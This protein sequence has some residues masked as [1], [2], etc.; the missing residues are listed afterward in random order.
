VQEYRLTPSFTSD[1]H[2]L[3][4][5]AGVASWTQI[6]DAR[7]G[8]TVIKSLPSGNVEDVS[9]AQSA[10]L[11]RV[12]LFEEGGD[13]IDMVQIGKAYLTA[14]HPILTVDG[15]LLASQAAAKG[16]GQLPSERKFSQLCG[17]QLATGGN[18]LINTSTTQ[19]LASV[20]IEAATLGYRFLSSPEPLN[21][22]FPT[23]AVQKTG[24]RYGSA[25]QTKPSYSQVTTLHHKRVSKRPI[26]LFTPET[27]AS[28][29]SIAGSDK[30]AKGH[31]G[32]PTTGISALGAQ[33]AQR[34]P[35]ECIGDLDAARTESHG[36]R[37]TG[38]Q[39]SCRVVIQGDGPGG[40]DESH[41]AVRRAQDIRDGSTEN[42]TAARE[43]TGPTLPRLPASS[44]AGLNKEQIT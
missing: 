9:G 26:P 25:D 6:R 35:E 33:T 27:H 2:I 7:C 43:S 22:N 17:L 23:Y 3:I 10:T 38:N 29:K 16:Y 19:D 36:I 21:G 42:A 39:K 41:E 4:L 37:P 30:T 40:A 31:T 20:Y 12:W 13:D 14:D 34:K 5:T 8:A 32:E 1:T 44:S 18:I 24:P 11:E 15:W 28:P